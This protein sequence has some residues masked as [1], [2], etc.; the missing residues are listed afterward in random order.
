MS[1]EHQTPNQDRAREINAIFDRLDA[2][3]HFPAY[4]LERRADIFFSLYLREVIEQWRGV[5]LADAIVP[6]IPLKHPDTAQSFKADYLLCS[7][8]R[9]TVF[10][11]ELKTDPRS[12]R[13]EQDAY[14]TQAAS[15]GM[16]A[17]LDGIRTIVLATDQRKKYYHLLRELATLGLL[18]LPADIETRVFAETQRGI[19]KV[20][21]QIEVAETRAEIEVLYVQPTTTGDANHIDFETFARY[22][23][24]H[25]DPLSQRFSESLLR[26]RTAAGEPEV[27]RELSKVHA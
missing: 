4:Q 23:R 18:H 14:L 15:A 17:L 24:R 6:E 12:R 7:S 19:G 20:L 3:R 2:W 9:A 22:V 26:W 5:T 8:D 11:V 27:K 10:L 21:Q 1:D 13:N 16:T 25:A